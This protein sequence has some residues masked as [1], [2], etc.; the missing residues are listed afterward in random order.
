MMHIKSIY[1][2]TFEGNL[3]LSSMFLVINVYFRV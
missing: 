3:N 2:D 1:I